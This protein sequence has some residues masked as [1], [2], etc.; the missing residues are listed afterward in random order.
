MAPS[1]ITRITWTDDSGGGTDGT[2]ID[3][4]RKNS[5]IYA[6]IDEM[7]AG[8]GSYATFTFGGLVAAEGLGDHN[9]SAGGVGA[10]RIRIRNT[11]AGTG[12]YA[13]VS[14]GNENGYYLGL[15]HLSA[16]YTTSGVY[17][18]D[19]SNIEGAGAGGL[20]IG[21]A[22]ASGVLVFYAG[23]TT[24][25][26]RVSATGN[27]GIGEDTPI[28][29]LSV[30]GGFVANGAAMGTGL[31]AGELAINGGGSSPDWA[32]LIWG[33]NT[34]Y[35]LHFGTRS[36]GNFVS[37]IQMLDQG[38]ILLSDGSASAPTLGFI[39]D[40][41]TG[42]YRVGTDALGIA[43][44]G[45]LIVQFGDTTDPNFNQVIIPNTATGAA[46]AN[47]VIGCNTSGSPA[48]GVLTLR[49]KSNTARYLWFDST[50]VLRHGTTFPNSVTGDTIGSPV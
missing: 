19:G 6:K 15:N 4:A 42:I 33:D 36:G 1:Q 38:P 39:S 37:R 24:E 44:N 50:G 43:R 30:N 26:V 5:D 10:N 25:R 35:K 49:D 12:N 27:V 40:P 46:G 16:S 29:R 11:S 9:F 34:G 23:G 2:I 48:P 3:N 17:I 8:A 14:V 22:H 20:S 31:S 7:F 18:A 47:L 13:G 32:Q 45:S 21:A 28:G 41:N